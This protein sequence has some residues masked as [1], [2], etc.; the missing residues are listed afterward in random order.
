MS[1]EI[2]KLGAE[3]ETDATGTVVEIKDRNGEPY[4][5]DGKAATMTVLGEY[6]EPVQRALAANRRATIKR[7]RTNPAQ[8]DLGDEASVAVAIAAVTAWSGWKADGAD[9][10]CTPENKRAVFEAAPWIL[11]QVMAVVDN[12]KLFFTPRSAT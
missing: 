12:P 6:A 8:L 3:K 9:A 10:P 5:E 11:R 4:L 7:M 2:S 1:L